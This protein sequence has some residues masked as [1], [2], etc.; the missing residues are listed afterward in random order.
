MPTYFSL[1]E[2]AIREFPRTEP[3]FTEIIPDVPSSL[4]DGSEWRLVC[5]I[6]LE[7][8]ERVLGAAMTRPAED[9][10]RLGMAVVMLDHLKGNELRPDLFGDRDF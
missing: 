1:T 8:L 6:N 10:E 7:W 4:S 9:E 2:L 3:R 5:P